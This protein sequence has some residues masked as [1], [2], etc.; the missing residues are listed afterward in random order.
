MVNPLLLKLVDTLIKG[1]NILPCVLCP[2]VDCHSHI[3]W[4]RSQRTQ[5]MAYVYRIEHD[6]HYGWPQSLD[7]KT[8]KIMHIHTDTSRSDRQ[9]AVCRHQS[10]NW[11]SVGVR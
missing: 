2:I 5:T 6:Q 4:D 10:T 3:T 9:R 11:S 8:E 7:H 1:E